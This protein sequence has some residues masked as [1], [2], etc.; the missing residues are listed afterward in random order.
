MKKIALAF[1]LLSAVVTASP[2]AAQD[3]PKISIVVFGAPSLGA[4][5]PPVIRA[6]KLDEKNGISIDFQER[7]P[8]AYTAQF[9]SGEF[10]V[11]GSAALL[12]VGLADVR[13]VKVTYLFNLFDFWGAVVTSRPEIKSIKDIEGKD[14]AAAKGTTNYVMFDWFARQLGADTSKFSVVNTATPGLV[15]YAL[16]DRATAVQLWEPAYTTLHSKKP[17]IRLLDL[18]IA[19]NWKKFT[20]STNIPYLGVA[21]H[22]AWAEKNKNLIPKLYATYKQAA[23]WVAKNPDDA[24]KLISAKGT[25]DDRKAIA[26]LIRANGR[27][28]MNVRTAAEVSKEI[29]SVYEAGKSIAFLPS[30]PAASTIYEGPM[31]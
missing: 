21:A 16:A 26:E 3:L 15:G 28:G 12:T 10:Q 9:N 13:G 24:A 5:L 23:E 8:D 4:F 1:G 30:D 2:L 18:K 25:D 29:K 20:G 17:S 6:Q 11:G 19:E 14:L 27:L 7:T 22:V 31:K